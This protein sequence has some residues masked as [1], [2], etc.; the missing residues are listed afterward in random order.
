MGTF[1]LSAHTGQP[2]WN[3]LWIR[4][5]VRKAGNSPLYFI[6]AFF[7]KHVNVW[8]FKT[9]S[10]TGIM[11]LSYSSTNSRFFKSSLRIIPHFKCLLK[12]TLCN[13]ECIKGNPNCQG[14][15]D[16]ILQI[17]HYYCR[18]QHKN[19]E[20]HGLL[21]KILFSLC[22]CLCL[23]RLVLPVT[24]LDSRVFSFLEHSTPRILN[25]TSDHSCRI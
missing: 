25:V 17:L 12:I 24:F 22:P 1:F 3:S 4:P 10:I 2:V 18:K 16:W 11:Q 19:I 6:A 15:S 14:I 5:W 23:L 13:H 8:K 21:N 9:K 20:T 7:L